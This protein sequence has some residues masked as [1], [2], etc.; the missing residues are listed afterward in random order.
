VNIGN[1]GIVAAVMIEYMVCTLK[2]R[3]MAN[4][5][6]LIGK[7]AGS[8][9]SYGSKKF[10]NEKPATNKKKPRRSKDG[11]KTAIGEPEQHE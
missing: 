2:E 11:G 1:D 8:G 3:V 5:Q 6:N 4:P 10:F 7:S 9:G